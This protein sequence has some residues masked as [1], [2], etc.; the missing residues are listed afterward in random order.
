MRKALKVLS[1][2]HM[3]LWLFL[4]P[5]YPTSFLLSDS[6]FDVFD[7]IKRCTCLESENLEENLI[8]FNLVV[9]K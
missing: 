6:D 1:V 7:E 8:K 9:Q 4:R 3:G 2:C 5:F